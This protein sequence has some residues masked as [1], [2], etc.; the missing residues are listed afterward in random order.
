MPEGAARPPRRGP[1]VLSGGLMIGL[2]TLLLAQRAPDSLGLLTLDGGFGV[3][4]VPAVA[5]VTLLLDALWR[6]AVRLRPAAPWWAWTRAVLLALAAGTLLALLSGALL[7]FA[8]GFLSLFV[9]AGAPDFF[10]PVTLALFGGFAGLALGTELFLIPVAGALFYGMAVG[11][12][13][14]TR[15]AA[16]LPAP[17]PET[18]ATGGT[19]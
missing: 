10:A 14:V 17:S 2:A 4:F 5:L 16:P 19:P 8:L 15:P 1:L 12:D 3:F 11:L 18:E 6:R 7:G 13:R 9:G